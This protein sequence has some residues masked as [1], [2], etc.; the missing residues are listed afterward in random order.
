MFFT[1][2]PL[3]L[4]V[5]PLYAWWRLRGMLCMPCVCN[6]RPHLNLTCVAHSYNVKMEAVHSTKTL[7][8]FSWTP[9]IISQVIVF[10]LFLMFHWLCFNFL[11]PDDWIVLRSHQN[12]HK[13]ILNFL[14]YETSH[15]KIFPSS[16]IHYLCIFKQKFPHCI[17]QRH[18]NYSSWLGC[19]ICHNQ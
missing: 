5:F 8:N 2:I 3:E 17:F 19:W 15:V 18:Y 13:N 1:W 6:L 4:P 14:T 10:Q 11:S 9:H 7:G 16:D 12:F